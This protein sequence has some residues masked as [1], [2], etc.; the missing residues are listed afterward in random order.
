MSQYLFGAGVMFATP[1]TDAN[2]AAISNPSPIG[3]GVI[4][5]MSLDVSF[6]T[7]KLHGQSQFPVAVGRG[8][9]SITGKVKFGQVNAA[10]LDS[11]IFGQGTTAGLI[12]DYYDAVGTTVPTTPYQIT[13]TPPASGTFAADLGVRDMNGL[14][15]KRVA[16]APATG[17]YSVNTGTGQYTFAAADTGKSV[18][19]S[20]QYTASTSGAYK[21]TLGNLLMGSAPTFKADFSIPYQGK[22]LKVTAP[23]CVGTKFSIGT[24]LDDFA[25]PEL[26]FECFANAL[27]QPLT[28]STSE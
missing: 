2:A 19:I 7:K 15:M 22:L 12:G 27:G 4:Q 6:D 8:K 26:D 1:L 20:F 10:V 23:Q 18:F 28:W 24:K 9:G 17:Q 13:V 21:Q 3:L 5:E 14:P 11:M 25:V 16:S